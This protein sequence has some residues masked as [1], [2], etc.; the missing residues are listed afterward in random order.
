MKVGILIVFV[1]LASVFSGGCE[2]E[3]IE[4]PSVEKIAGVK[5]EVFDVKKY[6]QLT[7]VGKI[8]FIGRRWCSATLVSEDIAVTA[9]HC[10]LENNLK[11]D[12][13]QDLEPIWAVV[14]FRRDGVDRIEDV[15]VKKV[16]KASVNPDYAIVKLNRKIPES[17]IKPLKISKLTFEEMRSTEMRLGCAGYNGDKELGDEGWTMTISRNV[18]IIPETS[19]AN[20]VDVNCFSADGGSGGLFFEERK[21]AATNANEYNLIGVIWGLTDGKF[22]EKGEFIKDENV[23]TSIT[24]VSFFYDELT[25][26]ISKN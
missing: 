21:D 14:N 19:S 24:P 25:E 15:Y 18:K 9:G 2:R 6:P 26:I 17:L 10:F 4:T 23:I 22:N 3:K 11:F 20:R 5:R 7:A 13:S 12:L 8:N 1:L 16:L